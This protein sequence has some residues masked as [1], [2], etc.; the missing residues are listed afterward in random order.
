VHR[1]VGACKGVIAALLLAIAA[2]IAI[3]MRQRRKEFGES[4][5]LT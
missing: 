2:G 1:G 3:S 5:N 4:E